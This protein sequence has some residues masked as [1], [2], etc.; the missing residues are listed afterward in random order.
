MKELLKYLKTEATA[1]SY[2]RGYSYYKSGAVESVEKCGIVFTGI[3]EGSDTYEV[4]ITIDGNNIESDCSCP[5]DFGG[6]CKHIVAVGLAIANGE[7][8]KFSN[9]TSQTPNKVQNVFSSIN[10][11]KT[12]PQQTAKPADTT[13]KDISFERIFNHATTEQKNWFLKQILTK[14][15]NWQAQFINFVQPPVAKA[16]PLPPSPI[17]AAPLADKPLSTTQITEQTSKEISD[18]LKIISFNKLETVK[19]AQLDYFFEPYQTQ[20]NTYIAKA[21]FVRAMAVLMGLYEAF[22]A[23]APYNT[24]A[25][26]KGFFANKLPQIEKAIKGQLAIVT[27]KIIDFVFERIKTNPNYLKN[28]QNLPNFA[29]FVPFLIQITPNIDFARYLYQTLLAL[30]ADLTTYPPN[31]LFHIAEL[32]Q[33]TDLW[34]TTA[35]KLAIYDPQIAQ[36][37]VVQYAKDNRKNDFYNL[38]QKLFDTDAKTHA[39]FLSQYV[40]LTDYP[41]LYK[42]IWFY[43]SEQAANKN[44]FS[45]FDKLMPA[46]LDKEIEDYLT[47]F[48][49]QNPTKYTQM[50]VHLKRYDDV[51]EYAINQRKKPDFNQIILP[52]LNVYPIDSFDILRQ[53]VYDLLDTDQSRAACHKIC[54]WLKLMKQ[55]KSFDLQTK[56]FIAHIYEI[57]IPM[58]KN[59][60]VLAKLFG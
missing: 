35:K 39:E 6:I 18:K 11:Q 19:I 20:I 49:T 38:A 8:S 60:M 56:A 21:D 10:N 42:Q 5:Y 13:F 2:S 54:E 32:T 25:V 15:A 55:I 16:A 22:L 12:T 58:L 45:V 48:A 57:K 17:P 1:Q 51:L 53:N 29:I 34:Y 41:K 31:L 27:Q 9:S 14:D 33:S 43:L 50:L 28:P 59:E 40:Q 7:Y 47:K 44:N 4:E 23:Q 26:M 52:L 36:K 3:V 30:N 24:D 46:L 37:L